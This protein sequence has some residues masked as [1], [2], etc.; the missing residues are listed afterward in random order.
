MD[1][2][3]TILTMLIMHSSILT[4]EVIV[5]SEIL[6]MS[7]LEII[8]TTDFAEGIAHSTETSMSIISTETIDTTAGEMHMDT[9]PTTMA[10]VDLGTTILMDTVMASVADLGIAMAAVSA[11]VETTTHIALLVTDSI[12]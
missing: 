11:A 5:M 9:E 3:F 7:H 12:T 6:F 4:S 1:L 10:I 2:I 8:D